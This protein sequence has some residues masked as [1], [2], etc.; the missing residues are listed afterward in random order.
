M[1]VY[2]E[3]HIVAAAMLLRD[4]RENLPYNGEDRRRINAVLCTLEESAKQ[5]RTMEGC[6]NCPVIFTERGKNADQPV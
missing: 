3:E 5:I 6:G 2:E 4:V 1:R